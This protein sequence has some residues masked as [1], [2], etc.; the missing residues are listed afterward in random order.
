MDPDLDTDVAVETQ[1]L[2]GC[3]SM[4]E[5][6]SLGM[7]TMPADVVRFRSNVVNSSRMYYPVCTKRLQCSTVTVRV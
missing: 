6:R 3:A 2:T 4:Y 7:S 5:S 1:T